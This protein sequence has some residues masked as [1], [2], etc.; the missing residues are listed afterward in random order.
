VRSVLKIFG[1]AYKL[2]RNSG[3]KKAVVF[4]WRSLAQLNKAGSWI[5]FIE[6][7]GAITRL[8]QPP[9][10]LVR[11]SLSTYFVY[12]SSSDWTRAL[13]MAHFEIAEAVFQRETL[14]ALWTGQAVRLAHVAG[15]K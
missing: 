8:G 9:L 12:R 10:E 6:H 5:D 15:R 4:Y 1:Y 13:L 7:Y 11:K 14:E 3:H 2:T